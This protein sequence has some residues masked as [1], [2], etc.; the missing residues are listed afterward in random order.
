[1]TKEINP[2]SFDFQYHPIGD[3]SKTMNMFFYETYR[4]FEERFVTSGLK[5]KRM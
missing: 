1:M 2:D 5:C 3:K 4:V